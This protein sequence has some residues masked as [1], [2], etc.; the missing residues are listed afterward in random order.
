MERG[1]H[2]EKSNNGTEIKFKA[3]DNTLRFDRIYICILER[4]RFGSIFLSPA[5]ANADREIKAL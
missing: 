3:I 1:L 4:D 2:K 5:A